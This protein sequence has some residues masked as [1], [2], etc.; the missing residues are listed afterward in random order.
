MV[1]ADIWSPLTDFLNLLFDDKINC[2]LNVILTY[3]LLIQDKGDNMKYK[4]VM[5]F[6]FVVFF[7][8]YFNILQFIYNAFVPYGPLSS[9]ISVIIIILVIVPLSILSA[10][11]FVDFIKESWFNVKSKRH[12]KI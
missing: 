12:P 11:K 9:I 3:W 4:L 10:L 8:V 6:L 5:F 7:L 2:I 1:S